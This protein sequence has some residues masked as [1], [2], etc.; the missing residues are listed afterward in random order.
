MEANLP[1]GQFEAEGITELSGIEPRVGRALGRHWIVGGRDGLDG[2]RP[3][4]ERLADLDGLADDEADIVAPVGFAASDAVIGTVGEGFL[5]AALLA[6]EV[7]GEIANKAADVGA[8]HWSATTLRASRAAASLS[9]VLA[10]LPPCT[11]TTQL[12]RRIR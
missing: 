8:H 7:S 9:M 1:M 12:V 11:P 3:H 5:I 2:F 10:K 4:F 6:D